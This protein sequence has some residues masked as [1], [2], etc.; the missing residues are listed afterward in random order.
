MA[1]FEVGTTELPVPVD[2]VVVG[3]LGFMVVVIVAFWVLFAVV[4]GFIVYTAVR[5]YRAAKQVGLDPYAG[6]IQLAGQARNSAM[7]APQRTVADRLA[8]VDSLLAAG[9][10]SPEEHAAARA[11]ILGTV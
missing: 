8:E 3:G 11:R 9:T 4:V 1:A 5:R 6:D 7:L 2:E 10:I